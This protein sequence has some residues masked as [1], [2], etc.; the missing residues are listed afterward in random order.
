MANK[1]T[2]AAEPKFS[3]D[4]LQADCRKLFGVTETV[5]IG[6]T[7]GLSGEYTVK[8]MAQIIKEWSGK[9]IKV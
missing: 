9:G 1:E 3:I 7:T 2:K 8:E 6:A 5:F 4:K